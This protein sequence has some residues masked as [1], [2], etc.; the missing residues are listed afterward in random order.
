MCTLG[1]KLTN[2]H[3][4]EERDKMRREP[5]IKGDFSHQ[6]EAV[7]GFLKDWC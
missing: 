1:S 2:Q 3:V 4:G 6:T 7:N 5:V